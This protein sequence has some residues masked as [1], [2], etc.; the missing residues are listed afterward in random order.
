MHEAHI[1][2]SHNGPKIG[3][4]NDPKSKIVKLPSSINHHDVDLFMR[5][6]TGVRNGASAPV[7]YGDMNG[8]QMQKRVKVSEW[9]NDHFWGI[10]SKTDVSLDDS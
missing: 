6:R 2:S 8:L 9:T 1:T 7:F 4:K 3:P 5:L 10:E